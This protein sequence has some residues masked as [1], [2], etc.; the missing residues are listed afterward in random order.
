MMRHSNKYWQKRFEEL[1]RN[2][3]NLGLRGYDEIVEQYEKAAYAIDR[4]IQNWFLRFA[5]DNKITYNEAVKE[6]TM[7]ERKEFQWELEDYLRLAQEKDL[8]RDWQE[9]LKNYS[10]K[11]YIE[12]LIMLNLQI[13]QE[14]EKLFKAQEQQCN[15][16]FKE[17]FSESYYH[18]AYEI[19]RG[20]GYGNNFNR[21]N[22]DK[23]RAVMEHPWTTDGK[24][25][26]SRI[27]EHKEQ[28]SETLK[29]ELVQAVIRGEDY[30]R[31]TNRVAQKMNVSKRVAGRLVMTE[32]AYFSS[33]AQNECYKALNVPMFQFIATLDNKT[34]EICQ[35][36]DNKVYPVSDFKP[37]VNAPPLHP[38]CRSC[39][40]PYFDNDFDTVR[41]ARDKDGKTY[42]VPAA[43]SYKEWAEQT[44]INK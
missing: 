2:S 4:D 5:S 8:S 11:L 35:E 29:N 39:T 23:V 7:Q 42:Y 41:A 18:A 20:Q 31:A 37:G 28:L 38:H 10:T 25:F 30:R 9:M 36:H 14:L 40:M 13:R 15:A 22:T 1:E 44:G 21:L 6:L 17:V 33:K 26:S 43:M 27:W 3:V 16:T 19:Q 34:S 24:S 32:S 12:R